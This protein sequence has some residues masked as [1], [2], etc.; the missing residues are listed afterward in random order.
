MLSIVGYTNAGK[1]TLLNA[2]T[3]ST[4]LV[5]DKLFAT[6]DP[7]SR[8]LRFPRDREVIITDTVG[9]IRDLPKDLV[10]AFRATLE[11]LDDADL[12]LHVVDAADPR[13]DAA[14]G[15]G[16]ADP[17]RARAAPRRRACWSSTR[18]TGCRPARGRPSPPARGGVAIS[19]ATRAGLAG[20]APPLRPAPLDGRAGLAGRRLAQRRR[21]PARAG[22]DPPGGAPAPR[23]DLT[24]CARRP[25]RSCS[26]SSPRSA[27]CSRGGTTGAVTVG[28]AEGPA[29]LRLGPPGGGAAPRP[30]RGGRPARLLRLGGHRGLVRRPRASGSSRSRSATPSASSPPASSPPTGT[31]DP[32]RG[33]GS[34]S[35]KRV[36]W[37]RGM[38]YARSLYPASGEWRERPTDH[39]RGAR[40]FRDE[41]FLLAGEVAGLLGP[42][43]VASPAGD[44]QRAGAPGP[45]LRPL[46]RPGPLR[47]GTV[48]PVGRAPCR[49]A[50]T[51]RPRPGSRCS[52]GAS[53]STPRASCSSTPPPG[54]RSRPG[55]SALLGVK[56][57][58]EARVRVE[59]DGRFTALGG[60]VGPVE[61]PR[62][63][64]PDE[65]K[66]R[67]V[68]RALEQAGLGRKKGAEAAPADEGDE[69]VAEE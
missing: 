30:R 13:R 59:V 39:G 23:G 11:E 55:I 47:A 31:V 40:R 52:T 58:P 43:L 5:E 60:E 32:G 63:A 33:P 66:P 56:G 36:I 69:D 38:S 41:S 44:G 1:S 4:V 42:A 61:P 2:L 48:P 50:P 29:P 7:T 57:D 24:R 8:R 25:S 54:R 27:A 26:R 19:A 65:R 17:G 10:A 22:A 9:F 64:L 15:R 62:N 21:Q 46:A 34:E 68:A 49:A 12:L 45:P 20:A 53:P 37:A 35:G 14:G 67:G 6:L 3:E 16:R 18:S 51:R 28:E